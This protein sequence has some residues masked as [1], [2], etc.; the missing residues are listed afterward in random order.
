[1]PRKRKLANQGSAEPVS[2]EE[3]IARLLGLLLVKDIE[4]KTGQVT[5]LR[6]AGFAVSEV[7]VMLGLTENH[8]NVAAHHGRKKLGKKKGRE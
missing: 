3:K 8:V 6:S 4:Q 2:P 1:M 5:T 7:A